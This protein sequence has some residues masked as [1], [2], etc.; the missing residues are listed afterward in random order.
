MTPLSYPTGREMRIAAVRSL[1]QPGRVWSSL[2]M[3]APRSSALLAFGTR[4]AVRRGVSVAGLLL[5]GAAGVG[6][7]LATLSSDADRATSLPFGASSVIAWS[8]GLLL[9][10][11]AAWGSARVDRDE[12]VRALLRARGVTAGGYLGA[13]LF[14]VVATL[15]V[16]VGAATLVEVVA[17]VGAAH[18]AGPVL[19]VGAG[20]L[21]YALAF[22]ASIGPVALAALSSRSWLRGLVALAAVLIVP[23]LLE[24][25]TLDLLPAPWRELTSIPAA[26]AAIRAGVTFPGL[27]GVAAVRALVGLTAVDALSVLVMAGRAAPTRTDGWA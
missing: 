8:G 10:L 15:G 5:T 27:A 16:A 11:G 13:R 12:G 21:A 22:A 19:R 25:W 9:A 26:L 3:L 23:L 4:L 7:A 6:S 17:A 18:G 2:G 14:G 1:A 24:R 20:A